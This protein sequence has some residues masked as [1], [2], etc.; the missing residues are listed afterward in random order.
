[1]RNLMASILLATSTLAHA[2]WRA[3]S[4]LHH[5]FGAILVLLVT[6]IVLPVSLVRRAMLN[7][8]KR[9]NEKNK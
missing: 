3:R 8:S 2:F 5:V 1:M 4:K 9:T 6:V 7:N